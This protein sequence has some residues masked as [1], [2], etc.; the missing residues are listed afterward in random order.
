MLHEKGNHM[1]DGKKTNED[2]TPQ[3]QRLA[4]LLFTIKDDEAF[5]NSLMTWCDE[6]D[7]IEETAD[8]IEDNP[9]CT[10]SDILSFIASF[11]EMECVDDEAPAETADELKN[12]LENVSDSYCDFVFGVCHLVKCRADGAQLVIDY[13]KAHP[14]AK[15]DDIIDWI[16]EYVIQI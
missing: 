4:D 9:G 6:D 11:V 7:V 16:E 15:S 12:L 13:I 8:F 3:E 10:E 2:L 1:I 5:V 14:D